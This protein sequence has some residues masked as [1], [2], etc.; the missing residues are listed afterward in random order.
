MKEEIINFVYDNLFKN[1]I[2]DIADKND[3]ANSSS[4]LLL[5]DPKLNTFYSNTNRKRTPS[6][7]FKIKP[8][9]K[10]S[11]TPSLHILFQ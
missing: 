1:K 9:D 8:L 2:S 5:K 3:I 11:I 6:T 7:G 4:K 10:R